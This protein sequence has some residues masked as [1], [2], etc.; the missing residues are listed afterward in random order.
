MAAPDSSRLPDQRPFACARELPD[1]TAPSLALGSC[2]AASP[3]RL[4]SGVA[5]RLH[6][7]ACAREL[8]CRKCPPDIFESA[9]LVRAKGLEPPHLAILEPKSS[10][11]TSSATPA[12][13]HRRW[14]RS[15][16]GKGRGASAT[17]AP[18]PPRVR[19]SYCFLVSAAADVLGNGLT[20]GQ[21][22]DSDPRLYRRSATFSAAS[23]V[24]WSTGGRP[25]NRLIIHPPTLSNRV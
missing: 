22:F 24:S 18:P 3:L 12:R 19:V 13:G 8:R 16:A 11:S 5:W 10:A 17:A 9:Q 23:A 7:F 21:R 2:L 25:D 4:R 1:G 15:I 6:P 20:S 14:R